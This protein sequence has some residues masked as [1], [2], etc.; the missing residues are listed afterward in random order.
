RFSR[1]WSSDVCSSDLLDRAVAGRAALDAAQFRAASVQHE[2]LDA[3][4][5]RGVPGLKVQLPV[6]A[7][8]LAA[9]LVLATQARGVAGEQRAEGGLQPGQLRHPRQREPARRLPGAL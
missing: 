3:L 1:D 7:A 2:L 4:C 6:F 9:D 8:A 5:E